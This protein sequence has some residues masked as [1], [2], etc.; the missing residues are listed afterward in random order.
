MTDALATAC[1]CG[2][3]PDC[4]AA[5]PRPAV[6]DPVVYRHGAI[7][8]RLLA[9]IGATEV[10]GVRP[11]DRLGTRDGD[12]PAI[13][14]LDAYAGS[15]HVLAWNAARL[16]DDGSLRRTE[17]RDALVALTRLLGYEPRPALAA[18]TTLAFT[19]DT[20]EGSPNTARVARGT[21]VASVPL[22]DEKPQIFETDA[23]LDAHAEWNALKPVLA[24]TVPP[25]SSTTTAITIAGAT[26]TAK[27]GDL[28][29]VYLEPQ[30]SPA[31]WLLARVNA[32]VR[33]TDAVPPR[34]EIALAAPLALPSTL[35][36][37]GDQFK[38]AVI[39]LGQRAAAFGA[40][41][42]DLR[43]MSEDVKRTQLASG[44]TAP[45][46]PTE[47]RNLQMPSG[48]A[49]GGRVDLDAIYGDAVPERFIFFTRGGTSTN[50]NQIG[51]IT[52]SVERS[53]TGF[54]LSAKI[55]R[56]HVNGIKLGSGTGSFRDYVR[57][58]AIH[59][60][61]ARETLLV[62]DA[63]VEMPSA[64]T[65]RLIVQGTLALPVGR[66]IVMTGEQWSTTP[67]EGPTI[68]EVATLRSSA[69]SGGNTELV[70]ERGITA[71][72]RSTTLSLLANAVAASHGETPVKGAELIGLGTAGSGAEPI[73]S[74]R[75]AAPSPRFVLQGSP[76]TYVPAANPRGYAPAIEVR[77]GDRLYA[78]RSTI[79]ELGSEDRAY[80]V[81]PVR[82]GK[83]EVQFAGRLPTGTHNVTAQYRTGGGI[84]GNLAAGRLTT[85][86][87]PV[88]GVS[89]VVNPV[90]AE[91]ASDA[92][93]IDD[94]RTA[95]PQS[96]R[97]LDRVVSIADFE[98]FTR[99]YRGIGK[100]LATELHSGMRSVVCLT[101]AT[102]DLTVP[103]TDTSEAL[104]DALALV[105]VPGRSIRIEGF[106]DIVA[107]L[108]VALAIDP[109]FRRGDVEAAAR[110]ALGIAFGRAARNFG[111]A[112]HR[113]AVLAAVHKIDGVVAATLPQF[114][115]LGGPPESD[116]RLLCPAPAMSGIVFTKAGLLSVDPT[117]IA[118]AEM[119]L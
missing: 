51:R 64:A 79:F 35:E 41:A 25:V 81:K 55:S 30:V 4:A 49:T 9:R 95:A 104:R 58:T 109:A 59:I 43:L 39:V 91:G 88:L 38:N 107:Q 61:T 44:A 17:D 6:A 23:E 2:T 69:A 115:L 47:W 11:L 77:V 20:F 100:A 86:M 24:K 70:F 14:L 82:D 113:S 111:E 114:A 72:F 29:L 112:L 119:P 101:I 87:A 97:T 18:T 67:G 62:L 8:E 22:Q 46:F 85:A 74:G 60:E 19:V 90:A 96:I 52:K 99:S 98:A 63:D 80:T 65:D 28:I 71:R 45:P 106:T 110:T 94:M 102:T 93:T 48:S 54:G 53:Q 27:P 16:F 31:N 73:G 3:C 15:L 89:K 83:S 117:Q 50:R 66:R 37:Q 116:G 21:K 84:V 56:I 92:E 42:P 32:V 40:T 105:C 33:K 108:A 57:A 36:Q 26:T 13:A 12:D 7:R 68:S 1:Y 76:L 5:A 75:A 34:I 10:E 78:E 103:G 118:F